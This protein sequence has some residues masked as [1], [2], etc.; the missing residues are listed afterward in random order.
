MT[1]THPLVTAWLDRVER[2][3]A[4]LS[5]DTRGE[6]LAD[7]RDHLDAA[8]QADAGDAAVTDVLDR[9]GD[10]V[11]VVA[12][13]RADAPPPG[14]VPAATAVDAPERLTAAEV[15]A[16]A[17]LVLAGLAGMLVWPLTLVLWATGIVIVAVAGRWRGGE[18]VG[19]ILLPVAWAFPVLAM[20]VP[21]G[22]TS[23][24]CTTSSTG[25]ESCVVEQSGLGG[26]WV[27]VATLVVLVL[28]VLGTRW[29]ARAPQGR[30]RR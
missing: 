6:L 2:L 18:V 8:L 29:L 15:V 4:D 11:D 5:P 9:L 30:P 1:V 10:P 12:A 21:V 22:S 13:A 28:I 17:A 3:A 24:S 25:D 27:L 14:Q 16:L 26:P 19:M 20:V 23:T 7:L